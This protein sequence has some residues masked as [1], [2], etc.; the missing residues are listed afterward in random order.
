MLFLQF[1]VLPHNYL[2]CNCY[3][4]QNVHGALITSTPL[5][6]DAEISFDRDNYLWMLAWV[7]GESKP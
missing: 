2:L 3:L 4:Q 7:Q 5:N 1:I 6:L